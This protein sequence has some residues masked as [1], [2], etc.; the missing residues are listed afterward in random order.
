MKKLLLAVVLI[1]LV[2][3]GCGNK[4]TADLIIG[5]WDT[6]MFGQTMRVEFNDDG[7]VFS[8]QE[9]ETQ[10]YQVTEGDP[11]KVEIWD[12]D[13]RDDSV[14]LELVFQDDDNATLSGEGMTATMTRIE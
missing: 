1:S 12:P 13:N 14:T 9:D 3:P 10:M 7:T 6:E 5:N 4:S 2:L 11:A 8:V